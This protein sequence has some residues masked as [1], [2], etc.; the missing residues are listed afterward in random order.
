MIWSRVANPSDP[1][2]YAQ[3]PQMPAASIRRLANL[4]SAILR[5]EGLNH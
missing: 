1:V 2:S 5:S 3:P 4:L